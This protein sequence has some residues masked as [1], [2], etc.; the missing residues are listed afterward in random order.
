MAMC[1]LASHTEV[2]YKLAEASSFR[3]NSMVTWTKKRARKARPIKTTK[4]KSLKGPCERTLVL[5]MDVYLYLSLSL[6]LSLYI[7]THMYT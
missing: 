7:Y 2:A 1:S 3:V 6:S 5:S 4:L